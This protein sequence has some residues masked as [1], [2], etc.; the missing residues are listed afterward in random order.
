MNKN[1]IKK[2]KKLKWRDASREL[3]SFKCRRGADNSFY[4]L[5]NTH[6]E[7]LSE[8]EMPFEE[9]SVECYLNEYTPSSVVHLIESSERL[10]NPNLYSVSYIT[11]PSKL[12]KLIKT[13]E[14]KSLVH[15]HRPLV[16]DAAGL[17][18]CNT[19]VH[20]KYN[21]YRKITDHGLLE[22]YVPVNQRLR[23]KFAPRHVDARHQLDRDFIAENTKFLKSI[24][25]ID[26]SIKSITSNQQQDLPVVINNS[27]NNGHQVDTEF[28]ASYIEFLIQLQHREITPEDYEFLTRLDER[29]K[30]KTLDDE[31]LH[32]LRTEKINSPIHEE[33]C[34]GICLELY[35]VGCLVRYLPCGHRFHSDCVDNWLR[36]QSVNCPLDNLPI[37][38]AQHAADL[39]VEASNDEIHISMLM[40]SLLDKVC[41]NSLFNEVET[42]L[43]G[44]LNT[45]S[46]MPF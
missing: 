20:I 26:L 42:V 1:I 12:K 32:K 33:D 36:N 22:A 17:I 31:I 15:K 30:K 10:E 37:D 29:I 18:K 5:N 8:M 14:L 43:N 23:H 9:I 45:I 38:A 40:E 16:F 25:K 28:D 4:F 39:P 2:R 35:T 19:V 34:C 46:D 7:S 24:L 3:A 41:E 27:I 13:K 11:R 44:I 6:F 21:L